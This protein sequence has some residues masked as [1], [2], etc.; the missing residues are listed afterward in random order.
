MQR[1]LKDIVSS[2]V[3]GEWCACMTA[4]GTCRMKFSR[5]DSTTIYQSDHETG[6]GHLKTWVDEHF[7]DADGDESP[8]PKDAVLWPWDMNP[9]I[10]L[11]I[12][13]LDVPLVP[14]SRWWV[15]GDPVWRFPSAEWTAVAEILQIN[16]ADLSRQL[17]IKPCRRL[18]WE[19]SGWELAPSDMAAG[20]PPVDCHPLGLTLPQRT[21]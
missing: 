10:C 8:V 21:Y 3:M 12:D 5:S 7:V 9:S 20:S 17:R 16:P 6:T 1:R 4:D 2:Y 14:Q 15:V 11:A 18:P 19:L 13:I